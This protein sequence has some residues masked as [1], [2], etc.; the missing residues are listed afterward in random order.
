MKG[1]K[2]DEKKDKINSDI[3]WRDVVV[4]GLSGERGKGSHNKERRAIFGTGSW[5]GGKDK[6]KNKGK[7]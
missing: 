4:V 3:E 1:T 5:G 2:S 6:T 7:G